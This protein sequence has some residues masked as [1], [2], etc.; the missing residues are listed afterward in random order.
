MILLTERITYA[1]LTETKKGNWRPLHVY[2]A[3]PDPVLLATGPYFPT[4]DLALSVGFGSPTDNFNGYVDNVTIGIDGSNTTYDFDP[5][6]VPEPSA[7]ALFGT[8]CLGLCGLLRRKL[9]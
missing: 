1:Q 6:P 7:I 2:V 4:A 9:R 8:V 3:H 5:N